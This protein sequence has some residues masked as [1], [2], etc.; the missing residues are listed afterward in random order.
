[1]AV[2]AAAHPDYANPGDEANNRAQRHRLEALDRL[3]LDEPAGAIVHMLAAI[4]ARLDE[5]TWTIATR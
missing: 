2:T 1:M 4:E 5:L 3:A